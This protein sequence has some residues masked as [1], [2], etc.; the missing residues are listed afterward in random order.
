MSIKIN[1]QRKYYKNISKNF[2][3]FVVHIS[4]NRPTMSVAP[5]PE[6]KM[7]QSDAPTTTMYQSN[8]VIGVEH[9]GTNYVYVCHMDFVR[10]RGARCCF[11]QLTR[12]IELH[13]EVVALKELYRISE[14]EGRGPVRMLITQEHHP[15]VSL[16]FFVNSGAIT[17]AEAQSIIDAAKWCARDGV[18]G[19]SHRIQENCKQFVTEVLYIKVL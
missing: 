3:V 8:A 7:H 12:L 18:S 1:L 19:A 14:G 4:R 5:V 2:C 9:S 16:A 11:N 13:P 15:P 6:S 17:P 10:D